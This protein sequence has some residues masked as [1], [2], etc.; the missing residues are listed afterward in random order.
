M[1]RW[2][3]LALMLFC[4]SAGAQERSDRGNDQ[5]L[6]M[7]VNI[8][9]HHDYGLGHY[10]GGGRPVVNYLSVNIFSG[11][12][13]KLRG[14][15]VG[16]FAN[17]EEESILGIQAAGLANVVDGPATGAQAAGLANVVDRNMSG[18]QAAGLAN[19][20]DGGMGG[21]QA[22]GLA[23]VIE[24]DL[25]GFQAAG[26]A[27]VVNG[28]LTG[29][30]AAGLVNVVDGDM[31]GFQ[32]AGLVNVVD[33]N[34]CG[35]QAS[36]LAN[37]IEG[38]SRGFQSTGLA[39]V[40]NGDMCGIQAAGLV[41]VV[42]GD[43]IGIQAAGLVTVSDNRATGIQVSGLVN[44][45]E[46]ARYLVQVGSVNVTQSGRVLP[47]GLYSVVGDSPTYYDYWV[48]ESGF[49]NVGLRSGSEWFHNLVFAGAQINDPF[50]WSL[51][52][53]AGYHREVND[54]LFFDLDGSVQ[55]INEDEFW[56]G[57]KNL[58]GKVRATGG[59]QI[60]DR[61]AIVFGPTFNY[62]VSKVNDGS[63][64]APW[65]GSSDR[66]GATWKRSWPGI[67]VGVRVTR[68]DNTL[69]F[70]PGRSGLFEW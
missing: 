55:H 53:G 61:I 17:V 22:A 35:I 54:R 24:G 7:P 26:L 1:K 43:L 6:H 5:Y 3:C 56:T 38:N 32:A 63:D 16:G 60:N 36:P 59:W 20:V 50:R 23:N 14:I 37:V 25:G 47:L 27:N 40:V 19:V 34:M 57:K 21:F 62:L 48:S 46:D 67:E 44:V 68:P 42:D 39:N 64:I 33:K 12:A 18:F 13:A 28:D 29:F 51:G 10:L 52:W 2:I 49:A 9:I 70:F 8:S 31:G 45:A 15:E 69:D 11:R 30:Q 65:S 41:D 66:S 58:L 4:A